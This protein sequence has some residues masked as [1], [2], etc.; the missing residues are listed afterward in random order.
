MYHNPLHRHSVSVTGS[1]STTI[2]T[3]SGQV[4]LVD[5]MGTR[6]MRSSKT[7][8]FTTCAVY[9]HNRPSDLLCVQ[10]CVCTTCLY[11]SVHQISKSIGFIWTFKSNVCMC[12]RLQCMVRTS[13][14]PS[15]KIGGK[16]HLVTLCTILGTSTYF[17]RKQ[18][19]R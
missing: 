3:L 2:D 15:R 12:Q 17:H 8:V 4:H 19:G 13:L 9:S 14:V 18:S 7:T 1:T 10:Y 16:I 5:T 11:D 6:L